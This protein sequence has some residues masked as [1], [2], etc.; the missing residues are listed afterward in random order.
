MAST[1]KLPSGRYRPIARDANGKKI[2]GLGTFDRKK[3]AKAAGDEA[4]VKARRQAGRSTGTLPATIT[5]GDW[6][7]AFVTDRSFVSDRMRSERMVAKNHLRPQWGETALNKISQRGVQAWIN[8]FADKLTPQGKPY[9]PS[10]IHTYYGVFSHSINVAVEEGILTASPLVNIRLPVIPDRVAKPYVSSSYTEAVAPKLRR[11]YALI[12]EFGLETGLRPG[13]LAGLHDDQ[14]D[15]EAEVL[16]ARTVYLPRERLM[17]DWPKNK[18]ER[19]IP[20]TSRA[21]EIYRERTAGRDLTRLCGV[22]HAGRCRVSWCAGVPHRSRPGTE[23]RFAGQ[24]D[25]ARGREGGSSRPDR[26]CVAARVRDPSARGGR[27]SVHDDGVVGAPEVGADARVR[28]AGR[29]VQA[30]GPGGAG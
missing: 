11:D 27:G 7:D 14:V 19:L 29:A 23:H 21:L 16:I 30:G 26:V 22:Q 8:G 13:E 3:D 28:P 10:S 24:V 1:E 2:P 20:L 25:E 5:W 6:W 12:V 4:E 15:Q 9:K 18:R 17:R